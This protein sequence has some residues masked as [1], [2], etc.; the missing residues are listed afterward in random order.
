M[1]VSIFPGCG[2]GINGTQRVEVSGG[3]THRVLFGLDT[4]ACDPFLDDEHEYRDCLKDI[5]KWSEKIA[6]KLA[7]QEDKDDD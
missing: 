4:A 3:T 7:A 1:F 6:S 5:R 2:T